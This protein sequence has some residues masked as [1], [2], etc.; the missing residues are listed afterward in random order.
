MQSKCRLYFLSS[1][2]LFS[3]TCS[4]EEIDCWVSF[5]QRQKLIPDYPASRWARQL[6][7]N[8]GTCAVPPAQPPSWH[9][10]R[11]PAPRAGEQLSTGG[12]MRP[13]WGMHRLGSGCVAAPCGQPQ[14]SAAGGSLGSPPCSC[15]SSGVG[16]VWDMEE[17]DGAMKAL[18]ASLTCPCCRG[19]PGSLWGWENFWDFILA[20]SNSLHGPHGL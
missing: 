18:A 15:P 9:G 5:N 10:P 14:G 7:S 6:S 16:V 3:R 13:L 1:Q 20:R 17:E 11:A 8:P 2:A 4:T 12:A 19:E